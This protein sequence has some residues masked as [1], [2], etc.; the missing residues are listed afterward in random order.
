MAKKY[1]EDLAIFGGNVLFPVAKS[2]SNLLKPDIEKFLRYSKDFFY[3]KQYTNNGPNVRLLEKRLAVFHETKYCVTFSSGFWAVVLAIKALAL[4][5]RTEIIMPS[6]TYRRMADMAA[7]LDLKPH[8]CEV[9]PRT[10]AMNAKTVARCIND[11]TAIILGAHPIVN[12]CNVK[13]LIDVANNNKLPILFDSV[14]S[15]YE[16]TPFGK[17]GS[18]GNA[19]CFS[20]HACKL[21]NGFGGGYLTTNDE[22]L[23]AELSSTRS[24]GFTGM[25]HVGVEGGMN[26]KLNEMHAAMA[27]ASLD[28]IEE[29][30]VRNKARYDTYKYSLETIKGLRLLKFDEDFKSGY[31]NIVV[32]IL[33]E[34]PLSRDETINILNADNVLARPYYYPPLHNKK[35]EYD[36]VVSDLTQTEELAESYLNLPCGHLVSNEE[37]V[38]IVELL[39]FISTNA[40][41]IKEEF[42]KGKVI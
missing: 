13:E 39:G 21:F 15:V 33:D 4:S 29:Q 42:R 12:C 14:E 35:M 16:T 7:W 17:V 25:D 22:A 5:G 9:D 2:T 10:L 36:Y 28:D 19:E 8:F 37:I 11:N 26:S 31:K 32:E 30:V 24:F 1:V 18:F 34:W 40:L 38:D 6:L 41:V 3:Q 27:L 23:A 20:L